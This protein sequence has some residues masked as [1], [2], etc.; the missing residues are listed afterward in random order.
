MTIDQYYI[1]PPNDIFEDIKANA[2]KIWQSYD[3]SYGYATEKINR[4]KPI[5]N[6]GDNAWYM[7]A[8]FDQQ[9]QTKLLGMVQPATAA[10][11]KDALSTEDEDYDSSILR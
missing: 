11:I 3:D 7:V 10:M 4:I 8:M 6:I 2:I 1:P 9:N 5:E